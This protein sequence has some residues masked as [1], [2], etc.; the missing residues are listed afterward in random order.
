MVVNMIKPIILGVSALLISSPVM[1]HPR[2][3]RTSW[4]YSYP[5]KDV[6]VRRDYKRCR[7][8]KYVTKYD[9][10]GWYTERKVLPMRSCWKNRPNV[11]IIIK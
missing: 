9:K 5:E 4:E 10:Y 7:K 6:M 8:I 1:S 3:P 11:K 2:H